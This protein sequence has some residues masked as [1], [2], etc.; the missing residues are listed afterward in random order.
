MWAFAPPFFQFRSGPFDS[1]PGQGYVSFLRETSMDRR[2]FV[3]TCTAGAACAA[4][5]AWP[6]FAADA[7]PKPYSRVLLVDELGAP[8]QNLR[9]G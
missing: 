4:G 7:R 2:A 3:E 1:A 9:S 6:V 5:A 8:V